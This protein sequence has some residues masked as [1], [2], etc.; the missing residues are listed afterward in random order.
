MGPWA[1]PRPAVEHSAGSAGSQ[2]TA[3]LEPSASDLVVNTTPLCGQAF[4]ERG[5]FLVYY[6]TYATSDD[7]VL[8]D[9]DLHRT[10]GTEERTFLQEM[11]SNTR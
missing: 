9:T 11:Q 10:V 5:R 1:T 3:S 7:C 6:S 4:D 2:I 8:G